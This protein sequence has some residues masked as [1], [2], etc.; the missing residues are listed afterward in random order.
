MLILIKLPSINAA[1]AIALS[2]VII[3]IV[4]SIYRHRTVVLYTL[5]FLAFAIASSSAYRH[6][7]MVYIA[8]DYYVHTNITMQYLSSQVVVAL[9]TIIINILG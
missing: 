3:V 1:F 4:V 9:H 6:R 2:Y 5:R 8:I 7:T